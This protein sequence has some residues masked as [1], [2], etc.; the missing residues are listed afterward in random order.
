MEHIYIVLISTVITMDSV[1]FGQ[2][3]FSRPIVCGPIMGYI[4]G[5]PMLGLNI[6]I[7]LELVWINT[8]PIGTTL[9]PDVTAATIIG[10]YW[11][12]K[13]KSMSATP[14]A[15]VVLAL[16]FALPLSFVYRKSDIFHRKLN[17]LWNRRIEDAVEKDSFCMIGLSVGL[18]MA[19]F[20]LK[21]FL[22]FLISLPL[23]RYLFYANSFLNK[24]IIDGLVVS[25]RILP[26]VGI[27][28]FLFNFYDSIVK[29]IY[30]KI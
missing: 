21:N 9:V 3:G 30:K 8:I 24:D 15:I 28:V 10:T 25:Y 20:F 14:E 7:I 4:L 2:F 16:I 6:G 5:D 29:L 1:I 11:A 17:S 18:S 27:G 26:A 22:L 19:I 23:Y 12:V 13:T